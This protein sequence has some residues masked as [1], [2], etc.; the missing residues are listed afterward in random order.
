VVTWLRWPPYS[1]AHR[2][3]LTAVTWVLLERLLGTVRRVASRAF[4][5]VVDVTPAIPFDGGPD[6]GGPVVLFVRHA[7]PGDSFLLVHALL[8]QAGLRPHVVLKRMLR[9]DPCLDLLLSRV[10]H[11]FVPAPRGVPVTR[12]MTALAAGLGDGDA[13]VLFPE[14]GNFTERRHRLAIASLRRHGLRRTARQAEHMPHVLPPRT[15]GPLAV[16]N[17]AP[18]ADVVFVAHTGLDAIDSA[19]H[20]WAALPLRERVRAHWWRIPAAA[21]PPG[22]AARAEW[23]MEQWA[24]VDAWIGQQAERP[25]TG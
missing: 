24:L 12:D 3:R 14:G 9:F 1:A 11:C 23:L 13:L 25:A 5:V 22:D 19:R 2:A 17:A 8:A 16:L 20:G 21:V 4:G 10:P 6:A 7:G 15:S 18:T